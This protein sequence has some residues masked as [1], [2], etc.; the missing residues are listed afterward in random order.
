MQNS[1][2]IQENMNKARHCSSTFI[3]LVEFL[4]FFVFVLVVRSFALLLFASLCLCFLFSRHDISHQLLLNITRQ[5]H[6][7]KFTN[8]EN[9]LIIM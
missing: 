8:T 1:Q 3:A 7:I 6:F 4:F 9:Y 5:A 2:L